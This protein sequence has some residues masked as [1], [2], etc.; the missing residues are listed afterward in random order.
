MSKKLAEGLSALVLDIKRG[1]GAFL[2]DLDRALL[3]A[4]TMVRL[5][6]ERQCPTAALVTAMDRPLGLA[7]GNALEVAE[8][9][10]T[11]EGRG[12]DDLIEL[13]YRLGTEMLL[14]A[15]TERDASRARR[16][17]EEAIGAGRALEK[18]RDMV[19]AQGGDPRAVDDPARLGTAAVIAPVA[20][21]ADGFVRRIEPRAIGLAV[22]RL[23]G[24][25]ERMEDPV[26]PLVG[27]MIAVRPGAKVRRGEPLAFVHARTNTAAGEVT[28]A[29]QAAIEIGEAP[30]EGTLPL[31]SHRVTARGVEVLA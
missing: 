31:V 7:C 23:G 11:L 5:G 4:G 14:L 29:V 10:A 30:P 24:G 8:A 28:G 3:L 26:D 13:T 19:A 27:L 18:F 12:P 25:R 6:E 1:S 16:R 22:I 20:A 9:V 17:L 15:G 2:P 21:A